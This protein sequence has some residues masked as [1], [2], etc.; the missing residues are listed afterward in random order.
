MLC[1]EEVIYNLL[2]NLDVTKSTGVDEISARMLKHTSYS[3]APSLTKLFNLSLTTG[4]F[5]SEWKMARVVPIPKTDNSSTSV[6]AY[7]PI[8]I[9]PIVSKVLER[10]VKNI[11]DD[12]LAENHPI[13]SHQWGFMHHRSST[14]ALIAVLHDWFNALDSGKEVCVVFFDV[15]KAFDSVPHIPL[16]QKLSN[17]GLDPSIIRW[18]KSYLTNRKQYVVVEGESSSVLPVPQ[19]SVL[20]PLLFI[21]YINDVV[22]QISTES[23]MS[24]FAD[25]ILLCT[26]SSIHLKT[27]ALQDDIQAVSSSLASKHLS[28]NNNKCCY[29]LLTRKITLSIAPPLLII[30]G[31]PLLRVTSYKYLGV[32]ITS[33]LSWSPHVSTICNKTRRLVGVLY[34]RFYKHS[35]QRTLLKLYTSFIRPHLEYACAAWDPHL[36]KDITD[37]ENV[38][39][40]ALKVCTKTWNADYVDLL[41]DS[42]LPSL[43]ARRSNAKL[44]TFGHT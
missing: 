13:S 9:L 27:V 38:Q 32:L 16:L 28:L 4:K 19:G 2:L 3:I 6:T 10:H 35:S 33:N 21:T 39:K 18:I 14:S 25:D 30:N 24:L 17:I 34:R 12:H 31:N 37:I 42:N 29:M 1:S 15:Q 40:F 41:A 8:S 7:R 43:A 5:P 11:L 44:C 23:N 36:S 26:E 20:G 22:E